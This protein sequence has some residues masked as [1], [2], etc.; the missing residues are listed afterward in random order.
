MDKQNKILNNY[1]QA[2]AIYADM[3]IDTDKAIERFLSERISLHCWQGDDIKG[4]EGKV[5]AS[6]NVVTGNH[7]GAAT[8]A[9]ELRADIDFVLSLAPTR[10]KVNLHSVY[11]EPKKAT[12]RDSLT[13]S[14]FS[15]W[16]EWA[17]ERGYGLDYNGSFFAHEMMDNGLSLTSD[18]KEV[19]EF[20]IRHLVSSRE[21]AYQIG[22][23]LGDVCVLNTW[24]PDGLKDNPADRLHYRKQL[25]DSLDRGYAKK[26]DGHLVDTLEGKLFGIG[27]ECFVAGSYDFYLAYC[28]K[29]NIGICLDSGH[30]HPTETVADKFS[31]LC[32]FVDNILLHISRGVRWDSDHVVI[33][34]ENLNN[35][36]F[37]ANRAG[38]L[39]KL[40]I[41][42][43]YFDA[44]INRIFA[45][46][47]GLRSSERVMLN[48]I[49][50]PI[51]K[52]RQAELSG[53]F[54]QRLALMENAKELPSNAV[55]EMACLKA[56][57]PT[58]SEWVTKVN[59][60]TSKVISKR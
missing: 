53:D 43:D 2:K 21:V 10:H 12:S 54:G 9:E 24:I 15:N 47:V 46:A 18:K 19:R 30:F 58:S 57:V 39:E 11:A 13:V 37:E 48:A 35:I 28:L 38:V 29:N 40:H 51:E 52:I 26:Y 36:M 1:E 20:W 44:S 60:Y 8:C 23:Q 7:P 56:N 59:E 27:T 34:D 49:L 4:F 31:A 50:E 22:K 3:G 25:K 17:K 42:L 5:V 6:E 33:A 14:D 55:W 16:I 32:Q 45:W 41:G